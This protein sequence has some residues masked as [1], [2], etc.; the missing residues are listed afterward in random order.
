[1]YQNIVS[2]LNQWL[3]NGASASYEWGSYV[4][5]VGGAILTALVLATP[6]YIVIKIVE[7]FS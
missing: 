3:F 6:F 7:R 4:T 1:M 5:Q 2:L